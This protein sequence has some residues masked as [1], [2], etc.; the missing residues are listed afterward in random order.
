MATVLCS[1]RSPQLG[2]CSVAH[3][4]RPPYVPSP[5]T[6]KVF[7][8]RAWA[9]LRFSPTARAAASFPASSAT[10]VG[11]LQLLALLHVTPP[12]LTTSPINTETGDILVGHAAR[13]LAIANPENTIYEAKRFLGKP[14]DESVVAELSR[15]PFAIVNASGLPAFRLDIPATAASPATQLTVTP[16]EIGAHVLR[17]LRATAEAHLAC[18]IRLVRL[19]TAFSDFSLFIYFTLG[20]TFRLKLHLHP[21]GSHVGASGVYRAAAQRHARCS[22]TG[23]PGGSA[24]HQRAHGSCHGLRSAHQGLELGAQVGRFH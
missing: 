17:R 24:C 6:P 15:F 8:T 11:R 21:A 12:L 7:T 13:A 3:G 18:D 9:Q 4:V 16:E 5:S 19:E 14:F 2:F 20:S 10:R 22:S 23:G 1:C